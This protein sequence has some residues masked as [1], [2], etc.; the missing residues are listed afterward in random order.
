LEIVAR[1]FVV[2]TEIFV[3]NPCREPMLPTLVAA[4]L[5]KTRQPKTHQ[6]D[7]RITCYCEVR[8]ILR[9]EHCFVNHVTDSV[10]RTGWK[11]LKK[12][13]LAPETATRSTFELESHFL[14]QTTV[15]NVSNTYGHNRRYS[16]E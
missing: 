8:R 10:E 5:L 9:L 2:C 13:P 15:P 6:W 12:D 16:Y 11:V 7:C 1:G 4:R 3:A 14:N